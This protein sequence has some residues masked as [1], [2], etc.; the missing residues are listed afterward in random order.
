M[1]IA[2]FLACEG[3]VAV[4]CIDTKELT[5]YIRKLH[6][7][8]NATTVAMGRFLTISALMTHTE[9]K[10]K[11]DKLTIQLNGGGIAG[12]LVSVAKI[13]GKKAII[14]GYIQN[15]TIDLPKKEEI[16]VGKII[17]NSGYLNIIKNNDYTKQGYKGLSPLVSGEIT[18]DFQNYYK[19]S[20]Q[21]STYLNADVLIKDDEIISSG[22]YIINLMPD[23]NEEDFKQI[24][25]ALKNSP[26]IK[27]MLA[28]NK[29]L[30]EI[31]KIITGDNSIEAIDE[32]ITVVY[33]C[34]CSREKTIE[35]LIAIGKKDLQTILEEDG[36]AN[37]VCHYC[38]KS[39]NFTKEDLENIIKE[40]N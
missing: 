22:G 1:G 40:L 21:K 33:E 18:E 26:S 38:N 16:K 13:D 20:N 12:S 11:S 34:D 17:G 31:A 2:K 5:K 19:I 23:A 7:L 9:I 36:K 3:R 4:V 27:Q 32:E 25:L 35:A 8:T 39:Y 37:I 15:P 29:S 30:K 10:E 6:S 14:K 24:E 28:E